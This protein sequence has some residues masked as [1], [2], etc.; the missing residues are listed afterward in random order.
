MPDGSG[1][2]RLRRRSGRK[3]LIRTDAPGGA[4]DFLD[5]LTTRRLSYS[6][7]FTLG[8]ISDVLAQ[9]PEHVWTPTCHTHHPARSDEHSRPAA[10]TMINEAGAK[11]RG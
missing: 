8:D 5:S 10:E 1:V 4:H 6:I 11:D 2:R 9:I 7:G 3:V